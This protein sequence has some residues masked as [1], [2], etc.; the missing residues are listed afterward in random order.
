VLDSDELY[1]KLVTDYPFKNEFYY[2]LKA[3]RNISFTIRVP[4]FAHNVR[5]DGI[6]TTGEDITLSLKAGEE[7]E[8]TLVFEV[9]PRVEVRPRGLNT[10]R[11][12]SLVFSIPVSYE[13]KLY[14][15]EAGGVVRA[16]PY[17]DYEYLPTSEWSYALA[18]DE[19]KVEH[20]KIASIPF[21][22]V[23]PA[24]VVKAKVVP[25]SW[26]YEEGYDSVCAKTPNS[27]VPTGEERE[28]ELYPYGNSKLRITEM[29]KI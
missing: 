14:E 16:F 11:C 4:S 23:E 27:T 13:K 20:R 24:V 28:I 7:S 21:S 1:V 18:S 17:C 6:A 19:L 9:A 2:T 26:G 15:Y 5:F 8:H 29:P 10:V 12:G 3:K 25:I 22:S